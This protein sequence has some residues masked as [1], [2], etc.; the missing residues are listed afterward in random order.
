LGDLTKEKEMKG[1]FKP[2][3]RRG[4]LRV[5]GAGVY[6][7]EGAR[8]VGARL[9]EETGIEILGKKEECSIPHDSEKKNS[10][11]KMPGKKGASSS[12]IKGRREKEREAPADDG[13]GGS[14]QYLKRW[15]IL[16]ERSL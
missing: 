4:R 3:P 1:R 2:T 5:G 13:R 14:R 7:R 15:G 9:P 8:K 12:K 6:R 10:R 11:A 16:H